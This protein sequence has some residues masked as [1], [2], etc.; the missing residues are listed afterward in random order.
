MMD[1]ENKNTEKEDVKE[2]PIEIIDEVVS[3]SNKAILEETEK[4]NKKK[5]HTMLIILGILGG[6]L[7]I[8]IIV[9]IVLNSINKG[10][11]NGTNKCNDG[12]TCPLG[13][14]VLIDYFKSIL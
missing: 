6:L 13:I 2:E 12:G 7:I 4:D 5:D 11:S 1:E 8:A 9:I 10:G 3:D 14:R